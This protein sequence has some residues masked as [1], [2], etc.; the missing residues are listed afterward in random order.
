LKTKY[1]FTFSIVFCL[2]L[3]CGYHLVGTGGL[4]DG[5]AVLAVPPFEKGENI[6]VLD[7]RITEAVRAELSRRTRVKVVSQK[8]IADA[9][10]NGTISNY[11]IFPISYGVDG[12]AD[13]YRVSI[14]AK[15]VMK[16]KEGKEILNMEGYR[17]E[18]EYSRKSSQNLF[19]NEENIAIDELSR[20]FARD[21]VG[22]ILESKL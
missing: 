1:L 20:D 11:S 17:F 14:V 7:Q 13:K 8:E 2:F 16:D 19:L 10:L 5:I 22:T 4:Q 18:R 21:L 3:S 15:V 12:R 6:V 9:V